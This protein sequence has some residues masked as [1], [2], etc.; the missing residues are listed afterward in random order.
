MIGEIA[1]IFPDSVIHIG[2]DEYDMSRVTPYTAHW[3]EC[4]HCRAI[5]AEKGFTSLRELFLYGIARINRIVN[6]AGKVMMMWNADLH[7]GHL[8]EDLDRNILFLLICI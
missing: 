6:S 5:M 1:E 8:P 3:M 7:P 4:P 2:A